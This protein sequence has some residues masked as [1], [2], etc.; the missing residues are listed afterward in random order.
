MIPNGW[1]QDAFRQILAQDTQVFIGDA[2][3]ILQ[4][5]MVISLM[6]LGI[7]WALFN[8]HDAM[9]GFLRFLVVCGLAKWMLNSY[10]TPTT[11]LG[12]HSFSG[13]FPDCGLWLTQQLDADAWTQAVDQIKALVASHPSPLRTVFNVAETI[14]YG[15]VALCLWALQCLAQILTFCALIFQITIVIFG[16]LSIAILPLP[17]SFTRAF[18]AKF[19]SALI[20]L[21]M[22][23]AVAAAMVATWAK[24]VLYCMSAAFNGN[25]EGADIF[26][27]AWFMGLATLSLGFCVLAA[28]VITGFLFGS[29][30]NAASG[31]GRRVMSAVTP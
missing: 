6:L 7:Q 15:L 2:Y 9:L 24:I 12:G 25:F 4:S 11:I 17:F 30:A 19:M 21:S 13:F 27:I 1:L 29:A 16:P 3:R 28:P 23:Q 10:W 20:A 31:F 14:P 26:E 22:L 18:F 5:C 8:A